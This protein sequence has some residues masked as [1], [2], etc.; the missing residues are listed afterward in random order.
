MGMVGTN[1]NDAGGLSGSDTEAPARTPGDERVVW[2][3]YSGAERTD[4][5]D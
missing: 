2:T 4:G 5:G 3:K 1:F